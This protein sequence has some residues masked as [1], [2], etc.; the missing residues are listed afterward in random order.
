M[1]QFDDIPRDVAESAARRVSEVARSLGAH[2]TETATALHLELVEAIPELRGDPMVLELLRASAESNIETFVHLAQHSLPI[3]DVAAPAAATAYAQRLAQRGTSSVA[4]IRA[5]RVGQRRILDHAFREISRAERDPEVAYA[6]MRLMHE[7]GFRYVDRVSELVV[8]A[9]ES[10]RERWLANRNTLRANT[11]ASLLAGTDLEVSTAEN[12]LGYRLRRHHL[13]VVLWA[14]TTSDTTTTLRRLESVAGAIGDAVGSNGQPLFIPQDR[15]LGWAW[16][17][18]GG[19]Q[20]HVDL[21]AV[22]RRAAAESSDVRIALGTVGASITGFRTS[23]QE[24][25]KAHSV[26]TVAA[27]RAAQVTSY[28][29]PGIRTAALLAGDIPAARAMVSSVLGPLAADDEPAQRLRE[30]LLVFLD[31]G[32]SYQ[33][34]GRRLRLHRNTVKYRIDRAAELRGRPLDDDRFNVELALRACEQLGRA[35]LG[36]AD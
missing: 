29:E 21:E 11:L 34:V 10:E 27:D 13:G 33:A 36:D 6:A 31:E 15:S 18:L 26:A 4:L 22:R 12:A 5:Y 23:H 16:I 19:N 3:G 32:G 1:T 8:V 25:V 20:T 2:I 7:L 9:Y 35:V 28:A 17:P 14:A 24:A 30:T